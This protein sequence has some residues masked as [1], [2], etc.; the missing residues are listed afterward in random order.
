M[1]VW[2]WP[3]GDFFPRSK[4]TMITR[5]TDSLLV[6]A[7]PH[8][9]VAPQ[10]VLTVLIVHIYPFVPLLMSLLFL[11]GSDEPV[12]IIALLTNGV[13]WCFCDEGMFCV[14]GIQYSRHSDLRL[15]CS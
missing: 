10:Q 11:N 2:L 3:M 7:Y 1:P 8:L 5:S 14:C 6:H 13:K 4:R 9:I 15:P 12:C